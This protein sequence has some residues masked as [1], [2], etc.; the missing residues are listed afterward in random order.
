MAFVGATLWTSSAAAFEDK[1]TISAGAGYAA[2][3]AADAPHGFALDV[4]G[5]LGLGQAWQAR[6][7]VGVGMHPASNGAL[8][9]GALRGEL[10][11]LV[12]IVDLV[13]FAGLGVSGIAAF[14]GGDSELE[15]AAHFVGGAA[16]WL[17]FDWLLEL[18]ARAYLMPGAIERQPVY[19]IGTLSVVLALDR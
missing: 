19:L 6:A 9:T 5:G 3:P 1:V 18:D 14:R 2:W 8:Q 17:S 4:Q 16:Y 7:G 10:V 13:P 11:Y 12:D 15:Y